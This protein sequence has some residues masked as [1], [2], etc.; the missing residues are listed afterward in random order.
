MAA[1]LKLVQGTAEW[2]AH[3]NHC[4]NASESA[5][6]MGLSPWQTPYQLWELR[7]GRRETSAPTVAMQHG[8]AMEPLARAAYEV[9]TGLIMQPLV[10]QDG[11]YS[12]SLDGMTLD[13]ER[14][15]EIKCPYKGQASALWQSVA[16][17]TV[18]EHYRIQIQHQLMVCDAV[19]A[20]LFVFDGQEGL[21]VEIT[22]DEAC[23]HAIRAAWDR[24][25][26]CLDTDTPPPLTDRDTVER[27]DPE[28]RSAAKAF[29]EAKAVLEAASVKLDEA[30]QALIGLTR[31]ACEKGD[32]VTVVKVFKQGSV[33]YKKVP[34]LKGVDLDRYRKPGAMEVRVGLS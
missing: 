28:W 24:F 17:G 9:Q 3:R 26:T 19:I 18:P 21:L 13:G 1:I 30:R 12:A 6:V 27:R 8:T 20:D 5:V 32:G 34:E 10:M 23:M 29:T 15:V 25:Q 4:R 11:H 14:I 16:T 2:L 33:D 31:H 22:R 7:T